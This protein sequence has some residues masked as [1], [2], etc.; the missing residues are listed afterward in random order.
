MT[1]STDRWFKIIGA[2]TR[3]GQPRPGVELSPSILQSEKIESLIHPKRALWSSIVKEDPFIPEVLRRSP[4]RNLEDLGIYNRKLYNSITSNITSKDF[5]LTI[6]GNHSIA[7]PTISALLKIHKKN[8]AVIWIDAHGDCNSPTTSPSG[9]YHGMPLAHLLGLFRS[10]L[11]NWGQDEL[12]VNQVAMIGIR[13][14]DIEE[15]VQMD[16]IGLLYFTAQQVKRMGMKTVMDQAM[17]HVDPLASRNIHLSLDVDGFDPKIIP[18]TGT[19][20]PQ[21]I[22]LFDFEVVG[23]RL[24]MCGNRFSSMDLVEINFEIEKEVTIQNVKEILRLTFGNNY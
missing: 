11:L 10:N 20:F 22:S 16:R 1:S 21:G 19:S 18:G 2:A 13:D 8:L 5:L 15:K 7:S 3:L 4:I 23:K 12:Q 6:G 14:L 9:N 24:Q 17:Q